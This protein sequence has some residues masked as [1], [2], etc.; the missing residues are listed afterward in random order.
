MTKKI[1]LVLGICLVSCGHLYGQLEK[2]IF[3]FRNGG[4]F[5]R[6]VSVTSAN[7]I[8]TTRVVENGKKYVIRQGE[9]LVEVEFSHTYGPGDL[10]ELKE[11]H[12][13]LHM[14]VTSFPRKSGE[15][16]VEIS[17]SVKEMVSAENESLL[18]EKSEVAYKI[19]EKYTKKEAGRGGR[20]VPFAPKIELGGIELGA[21]IPL[22]IDLEKNL[23]KQVEEFQN[24][25]LDRVRRPR[26]AVPEK[27]L[28]QGKDKPKSNKKKDLIKT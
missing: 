1:L 2:Q 23:R 22:A 19:F 28:D 14:H 6:S 26:R 4:G 10:E 25:A 16:T 12:P 18:Q 7:G 5:S 21:E 13:D 27:G 3:N 11:K 15:S 17:V 8:K 24:R 9:N 20:P